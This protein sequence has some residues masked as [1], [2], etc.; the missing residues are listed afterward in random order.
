[1]AWQTPKTNWSS[2]DGVRDTDM[3]RIEGNALELKNTK[4]ELAAFSALQ[5]RV[6]NAL[7][8]NSE[9]RLVI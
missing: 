2:A 4:A 1:M 6:E 9:H 7:F 3:N 5:Q 8:E